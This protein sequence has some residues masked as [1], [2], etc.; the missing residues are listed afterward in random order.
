MPRAISGLKVVSRWFDHIL[1]RPRLVLLCAVVLTLVAA[2]R[3]VD[4]IALTPRFDIDPSMSALL[5]RTGAAVDTFER[6]RELFSDDD[7]LFVAWMAQDL[8][9]PARLAALRQ[10][11]QRIQH[12]P[13]VA[14]VDSLA[15]AIDVAAGDDETAIDPFLREI[16]A[17]DAAAAR[18]QARAT[19]NPLFRGRLLSQ[20][21]R[22]ALLAVHFTPGLD[23]PTLIALVEAIG[24]ASTAEAGGIEQFLSGP[25]L[26][27]L[28]IS[29]ILLRDLYRVVPLAVLGTF[30]VAVVAFRSLAGVL[31]PVTANI[32]AALLT[33]ML[34]VETGH[35]LNFVTVIL[36]SVVYVVGFAYAIHVVS[37]F[38]RRFLASGERRQA[39]KSASV[40]VFVPLTVTAMTTAIA[41]A[42]LALS[43]IESIR[44]FGLFAAL[45]VVL[46]W[47]AS[48]TIVPAGLALL[49]GRP[50]AAPERRVVAATAAMLARFSVTHRRALILAGAAIALGS[51]LAATRIEVDTEVL[52]NFDADSAVQR[53]FQ[54]IGEVFA[55]PV[56]LRILIEADHADAFKE[57]DALREIVELGAWLETQPEIGQVY[58]LADYVGMLH[59]A[60]APEAA[61]DDPIPASGRLVNHL[62]LLGGSSDMYRFVD[63]GFTSTLIHARTTALSTAEVNALA[64]RV[65]ARL[66][67]LPPGLHGSVTGTSYLIARTVDD[68]TRGQATSLVV[69]LG[70]IF[71]VLSL[72]FGSFRIGALALVPNAL[73]V[74]FYFGLLGAS[75][76][77]LSLTTSLVACAVFG[78]A[79]DDSVH[80]LSRFAIDSRRT[81]SGTLGVEATLA[82]I[83]RPVS[84]TTAALCVGFLAL[85]AG[86]L[87]SQTEFGLLA[88]ATLL[89]A[90]LVDITF[91]PALCQ[92]LRIRRQL[93]T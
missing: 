82:T 86:E 39:A 22:S 55:G 19:A 42:A 25:L 27:R 51:A 37:E 24:A 61:R 15:T 90:W 16:P 52:R 84:V 47:A 14:Q 48:L 71:L 5:P 69:A 32:A 30:I 6:A 66:A 83:L 28:E 56:P 88:A 77:T 35:V 72:L 89:F 38:D 33:L 44:T 10:L 76:I 74:A 91:T 49:P 70:V 93:F 64:A 4:P 80:F 29:R 59:H 62:L 45:G 65:E 87:K 92:K 3:L 12:L 75:S 81:G 40:E 7:I 46:A 36:P 26:V 41:F 34:F 78:I 79:I 53:H 13:G 50:H 17:D 54:R 68:I 85:T 73:P 43:N 9:A 8:F 11:T 31:L 67:T 57:P 60:I 58:T 2:G 63:L 21:G 1:A 20:D 23:T 18:A